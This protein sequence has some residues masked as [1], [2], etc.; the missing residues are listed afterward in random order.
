MKHLIFAVAM[1]FFFTS[2]GS[3]QETTDASKT[4]ELT[5]P[6]PPVA[7]TAIT[8]AVTPSM[9]DA[10]PASLLKAFP[11]AIGRTWVYSV[12]KIYAPISNAVT[13]FVTNTGIITETITAM[14]QSI[15]S[16]VFTSTLQAMPD[17]LNDSFDTVRRYEVKDG[18]VTLNKRITQLR[19]PLKTDQEWD[20]FG[21]TSPGF[22]NVYYWRVV[23]EEDVIVPAGHFENC[24]QLLLWTNP[25]HTTNWFC[26]GTGIV[27][28]EYHH[29][30]TVDHQYW[31]LQSTQAP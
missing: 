5:S 25:D 23:K 4:L 13:T 7:I 9:L 27:R 16:I 11:L 8:P 17:S 30:G 14:H 21:D 12:T 2:C 10:Q 3:R 20:A 28:I 29:H 26:A 1:L 19:W 22:R 18:A 6:A 15:E 24:F 31:E